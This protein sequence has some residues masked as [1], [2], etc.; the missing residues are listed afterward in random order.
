MIAAYVSKSHLYFLF[1]IPTLLW[2]SGLFLLGPQENKNF[3]FGTGNQPITCS[4]ANL[5]YST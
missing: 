2:V 3:R 5:F 4:F 1:S